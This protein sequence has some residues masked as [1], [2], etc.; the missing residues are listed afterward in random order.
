[1]DAA[2]VLSFRSHLQLNS[3]TKSCYERKVGGFSV[4]FLLVSG[5]E[6]HLHI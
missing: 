1:M 3:E 6:D 5:L 2:S 4:F